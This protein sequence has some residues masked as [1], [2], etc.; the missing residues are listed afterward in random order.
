[1][2]KNENKTYTFTDYG[3][4]IMT[5][6]GYYQSQEEISPKKF[7]KALEKQIK[8][9]NIENYKYD[10]INEEFSFEDSMKN[11][12]YTIKASNCTNVYLKKL[13]DYQEKA[14]IMELQKEKDQKVN[15]NKKELIELAKKGE[16]K[17]EYA[18]EVYIK[19]LKKELSP[20]TILNELDINNMAPDFDDLLCFGRWISLIIGIL[21]TII[22]IL[23]LSEVIQLG[24]GISILGLGL[25]IIE[26]VV[27]GVTLSEEEYG[28][29]LSYGISGI[30]WFGIN[31]FKN[32]KQNI[33]KLFNKKK[34]AL[35]T[36]KTLKK[37]KVL[38]KEEINKNKQEKSTMLTDY[39][40]KN[41]NNISMIISF[42]SKLK[43]ED[44]RKY[45]EELEEKLKEYREKLT[46]DANM[47]TKVQ[48]AKKL[49]EY[50]IDLK[51]RILEK[52]GAENTFIEA[53]KLEVSTQA[54]V[55]TKKY[56]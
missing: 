37:Y 20:K 48:A 4:V 53:P 54:A 40:D 39:I 35:Y 24:E 26:I 42:T 27:S 5:T 29:L 56:K 1:M 46:T 11:I 14:K 28:S 50:V 6:G 47:E 51:N 13:F 34:R 32:I 45:K 7:F 8:N 55:K 2:Y 16:I 31:I 43:D 44:K 12:T 36:L 38:T 10:S 19:E 25:S 15:K 33:K 22:T 52:T 9:G 17:S 30:I 18:K 41:I 3:T 21:G 49:L 23:G